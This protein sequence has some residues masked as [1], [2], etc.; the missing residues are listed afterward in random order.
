MKRFF[1]ILLISSSIIVNAEVNSAD[2]T[3]F[4]DK[5][6]DNIDFHSYFQLRGSTDFSDSHSFAVRRLKFWIKSPHGFSENWSYKVQVLF[7]SWMQE[8]FFLQDAK[9]GYKTGR[10]SFDIGQFIPQYSLQRFQPDYLIPAL[11]RARA[12]NALIPDGTMGVR[13]IGLQ[14]HYSTK[15]E[16]FQTHLGVFNGYGIKEYRFND[17]GYMVTNK[18]GINLLTGKTKLKFGY[19]LQ[20]RLADDL[21]LRFIFPD[22]VRYNGNDFRYNLFAMYN[23]RYFDI[24][25]EYLNA[26]FDGQ[27][28]W[29]Y[30]VLSNI[31]FKKHQIILSFEDYHD[32]IPATN[33]KPYYRIGY[34]YLIKNYRIMLFFDNYFQF[35]DKRIQN[36]KTSVQLQ[37]FIK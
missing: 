5:L 32:L 11:E 35:F 1:L 31:H 13:D 28:A 34:N 17:N 30:Y 24:Q 10:F 9:I 33:D 23:T 36:Y 2:T 22:S 26:N 29:G 21:Q 6:I 16:L 20:Y 37:F 3:S 12:I 4:T 25:A 15:N 8:K 18:S 7:T 19:S 27:I 14:A